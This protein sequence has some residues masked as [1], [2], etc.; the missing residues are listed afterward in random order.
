MYFADLGADIQRE[1]DFAEDEQL[2]KNLQE[3]IAVLDVCVSKEQPIDVERVLNSIVSLLIQ[4]PHTNPACQTL[5][6][7][8]LERIWASVNERTA[9]VCLRVLQNL[10]EGLGSNSQL[11]YDV[12]LSLLQISGRCNRISLVFDEVPKLAT[13]LNVESVGIE[14]VQRLY[15]LLHKI[16]LQNKQR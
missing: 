9:L 8:F 15:R 12:Y 10:F 5:I 2:M 14:K 7:S 6:S 16:L 11:K 13:W 3:I 4:V 1:G